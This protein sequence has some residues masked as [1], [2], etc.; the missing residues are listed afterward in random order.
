MVPGKNPQEVSDE[1]TIKFKLHSFRIKSKP[2]LIMRAITGMPMKIPFS[3]L[4]SRIANTPNKIMSIFD[5]DLAWMEQ[6]DTEVSSVPT[7][8]KAAQKEA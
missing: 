3:G 6:G 5:A 7:K 8:T 2:S 4:V 1:K